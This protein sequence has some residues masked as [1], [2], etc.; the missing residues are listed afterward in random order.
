MKVQYSG[1]KV[2]VTG[3]SM[4]IGKG[5]SKCFAKDGAHLFLTDLPSRKEQLDQW[6]SELESDHGIKTWTFCVDLTGS[7]GPETLYQEVVNNAGELDVLVNNAGICSY[8]KFAEIPTDRLEKMVLLNCM[9]YAKLMQLFLPSMI[10]RNSGSILNISSVAAFQPLPSLALYAATKA[11]TQSLT[12]GIS[13]DLPWRSK[14][15]VATLNPPFTRTFLINDAGVPDDFIP[16]TI[17]FKTVDEVVEMGYQAFKNG[18]LF[19]VPG[20]QN[21]VLHLGVMKLLPRR[22]VNLIGR[23]TM[24]RWSDYL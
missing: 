16:F 17:S 8:G 10:A 14:V 2:L 3:S 24:K 13:G 19:Y 7:K 4:G 18:K 23:L 21:K 5:L 20:W 6:A 12:E 11:F 9:G 22:A 1:K 15:K